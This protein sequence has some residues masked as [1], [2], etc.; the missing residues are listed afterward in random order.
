MNRTKLLKNGAL[1][2]LRTLSSILFPII[3][4]PY[5]SRVLSVESF[6]RYNFANSFISYFVLLASLGISTY[7]I[8]ECS[9]LI[10]KREDLEKEASQIF[11]INI[12]SMLISYSV[13][14]ATL[15][16][17]PVFKGYEKLIL[18][19]SLNIII[20]ILGADWMNT[21]QE[22][23][24]FITYRTIFFQVVAL[25]CTVMFVKEPDDYII[26]AVINVLSGSGASIVNYFYIRRFCKLHF[27]FNIEWKK[28]LKPIILMFSLLIAQNI[29]SNL[30]ITM[31]GIMKGDGLTGLYSMSVRL[32]VT[33]EK[34]I[35][36]IALV[37]LPQ[38][39]ILFQERRY[40]D[41]NQILHKIL[42]FIYTLALPCSI[43][44][45]ML[46]KEILVFVCGTEYSNAAISLAILS[47][48]MFVNLLGG[49]W[50]NIVLLPS[51]K[52]GRFMLACIV[53][54]LIN[55]FF[56]VFFIYFWG[57]EGAA[58]TTVISAI[59]IYAICRS[60]KDVV[61]NIHLCREEIL[62]PLVGGICILIICIVIKFIFVSY[63]WRIV[64]SVLFSMLGYYFVL[65]FFGND[66]INMVNCNLI[67]KEG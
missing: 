6:G 12:I 18:V 21:A 32:Y 54:A 66:L 53:S 37:L 39:S 38:M 10:E 65:S 55:S 46:S 31:I 9:Q 45:M 61:I 35:S 22:D 26:F 4:I 7:A 11:S 56:N 29:L 41:I 33:V 48:S 59:T 34:V 2:A 43:G 3:T 58:V 16:F 5:V 28:H 24:A 36:S 60:G 63:F 62:G 42:A 23:F 40:E 13:L 30:D 8:R 50:G 1:N 15:T 64:Y 49:F 51:G 25:I 47:V 52:E 44:L 20:P 27:T 19:L 67:K 14:F 57:I 17:C